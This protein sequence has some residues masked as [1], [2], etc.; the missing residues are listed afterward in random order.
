MKAPRKRQTITADRKY[1]IREGIAIARG[2]VLEIQGAG[3][4]RNGPELC[5]FASAT[6]P[7]Q[8]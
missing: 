4:K 2:W 5:R 1:E 3:T 8:S 6:S 7:N